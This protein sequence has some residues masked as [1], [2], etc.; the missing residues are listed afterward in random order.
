MLPGD[1][2][3]LVKQE[4][5][6]PP[7][8]EKLQRELVTLESGPFVVLEGEKV[9]VRRWLNGELRDKGSKS[10]RKDLGEEGCWAFSWP[11][12]A[13]Y[14]VFLLWA[15]GSTFLTVLRAHELWP[16]LWWI[17]AATPIRWEDS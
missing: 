3:G 11:K 6:F 17:V 12:L 7:L 16:F 8:C 13:V 4:Q 10:W 1:L 2:R 15:A 5:N 14:I 9:N